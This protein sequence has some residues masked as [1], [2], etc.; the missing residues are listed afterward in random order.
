[1]NKHEDARPETMRQKK[2]QT[3]RKLFLDAYFKA[4]PKAHRVNLLLRKM[5]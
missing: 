3:V 5:N 4:I 2:L 1:M